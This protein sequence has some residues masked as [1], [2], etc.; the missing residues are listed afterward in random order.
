MRPVPEPRG[1]F[2][3]KGPQEVLS[4]AGLCVCQ[5]YPDRRAAA[6]HGGPGGAPETAGA[7]GERGAGAGAHVS[8]APGTSG[9]P[10]AAPGPPG[11]RHVAGPPTCV[12]QQPAQSR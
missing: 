4:V 2:R 10:A 6:G 1:S 9:A 12:P 8:G 3:P 5:V 11:R 7:G